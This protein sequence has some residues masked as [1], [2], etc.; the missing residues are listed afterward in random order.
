M[1]NEQLSN[2]DLI[3]A[4]MMI[5]E[6]IIRPEIWLHLP[7]AVP[8]RAGMK[9][10]RALTDIEAGEIMIIEGS[11]A[12]ALAFYSW[13]KKKTT[14]DFPVIDHTSSRKNRRVFAER[15]GRIMIRIENHRADLEKAPQIPW[16]REF[17]PGENPFFISLPDLLGMNGAW[18]WFARGIKYTVLD[19][20]IHPFYGVYFPVRTTHLTLLDR[21]LDANKGEFSHVTDIGTGCGILGF[22]ALRH[23]AASVIATDINPNAVFSASMDAVR[24]GLKEKFNAEQASLFGKSRLV[25]GDGRSLTL[26]NPPW[27]PG[28]PGSM[29][30]KGIYYEEGFFDLLISSAALNIEPG[31]LMA[32]LFSDYAVISGVCDADPVEKAVRENEGFSIEEKVTAKV[33]ERPGKRSGTWINQVR[34]NETTCIWVLKRG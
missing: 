29:I 32:V 5:P 10:G 22:M 23:G 6:N 16:L 9:Y 4:G 13:L 25:M 26:V 3:P 14:Y 11:F 18:Q 12:T 31:G 17:Y 33:K 34:E 21:W 8:F 15:A 27:I 2:P 28:S 24:M 7:R 1:N 19:H 30:D 20:R